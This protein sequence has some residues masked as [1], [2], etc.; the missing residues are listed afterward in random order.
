MA[1]LMYDQQQKTDNSRC[2]QEQK[3]KEKDYI[4]EKDQDQSR[5]IEKAKVNKFE[6]N[7]IKSNFY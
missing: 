6:L 3:T 5:Q 7:K 1:K 2:R 4:I